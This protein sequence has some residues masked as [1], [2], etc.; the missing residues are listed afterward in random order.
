MTGA[1]LPADLPLICHVVL[2]MGIGGMENGLVRLT[3]QPAL[4]EFR[5]CVVCLADKGPLASELESSGIRVFSLQEEFA[6]SGSHFPRLFRILR[7]LRPDLVHTRN[8]PTSDLPAI[9]RLAGVPAIVHSEHGLE[10]KE[11]SQAARRYIW[12][13]R[14]SR[15]FVD[16][17]ITLGPVLGDWLHR[18]IGVDRSKIQPVYNGVDTSV[19]R[20]AAPGDREAMRRE[21]LPQDWPAE[22]VVIGAVGRLSAVKNF[23][24]LINAFASLRKA[25]GELPRDLKLLIVGDGPDR[26]KLQD[27]TRSSGLQ[28]DVSLAGFSERIPDLMACMDLFVLPS[29]SEGVSNTVLEAQACGLPVVATRVGSTADLLDDG[30]SGILVVP[31]SSEALQQ[32]LRELLAD[33][34]KAR[35]MGQHARHLVQSRFSWPDVAATYRR[36]YQRAL[37]D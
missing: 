34:E 15:F 8:L 26:D 23:D 11:L 28:A 18:E 22:S 24:V 3:R 19:F 33:P 12:V 35:Q 37:A 14:F 7:R 5:H 17:Y 6:G 1:R 29:H 10:T 27:L 21:L 32:A 16:E 20:P 9:A 31:D 4:Q 2:R 30:R 13:R 25:A 36:V